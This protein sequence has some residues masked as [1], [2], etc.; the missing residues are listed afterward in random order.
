MFLPIPQP[1]RRPPCRGVWANLAILSR[2]IFQ[3]AA[4]VPYGRG[5]VHRT[6]RGETGSDATSGETDLGATPTA[7]AYTPLQRLFFR[8]TLLSIRCIRHQS[9]IS[10]DRMLA[11]DHFDRVIRSM[12]RRPC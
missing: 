8:E 5:R 11:R 4:G 9:G 6:A 12:T 1:K 10:D 2:S 7:L 3:G